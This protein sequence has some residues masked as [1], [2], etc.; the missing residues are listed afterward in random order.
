MSDKFFFIKIN[1]MKCSN[2]SENVVIRLKMRENDE[3]G[4]LVYA[5]S[6]GILTVCRPQLFILFLDAQ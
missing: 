1:T 2:V 4:D 5:I 6:C 3:M